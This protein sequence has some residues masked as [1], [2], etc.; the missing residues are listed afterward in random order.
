MRIVAARTRLAVQAR[1]GLQIVV[2]HVWRRGGEDLERALQAAAEIRHQDLQRG[3]RR[4]LADLADAVDEMLRAAVAQ[5]VAIDAGDDDVGKLELRDR[6]GEVPRLLGVGRER[7]AVRDV[8]ER[9]AP[10][11]DVAEDH[12]RRRALAEA[13]GDV[14][15]R[16][17]LADRVQ[18][19]L[20]QDAL[21]IVEARVGRRGAHADPRRLRER[22]ARHDLDRDARGFLRAFLFYAGF[23][24]ARGSRERS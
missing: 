5:I 19:L 11:A 22:L 14:R 18:A 13:L 3:R 6:L 9:A 15:A 10:G 2:H 12:E 8:A 1:H 24:H 16:R 4:G 7:A 17:L 23:T 20:A 21:D